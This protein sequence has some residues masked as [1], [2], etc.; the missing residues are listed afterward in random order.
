MEML[1]FVVLV[2]IDDM[3]ELYI[4]NIK[5]IRCFGIPLWSI[6]G[7]CLLIELDKSKWFRR[8]VAKSSMFEA[9]TMSNKSAFD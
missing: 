3:F 4:V 1:P 5:D 8:N 2:L 9:N 6:R 7:L